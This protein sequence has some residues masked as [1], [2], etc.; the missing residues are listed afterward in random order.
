VLTTDGTADSVRVELSPAERAT[1]SVV[2]RRGGDPISGAEIVVYTDYGVRHAL[3]NGAGSF[4]LSGLAPGTAHLL[5]RAVGY[6]TLANT[7]I[8]PDS[9]GRHDCPVPPIELEAEGVVEGIVVDAEGL[10]VA[11]ARVA[12]DHAPTW[13]VAGGRT[14]DFAL[15]DAKGNFTVHQLPEGLVTLEA[16]GPDVGRGRADGVRVLAGRTTSGVIISL[17]EIESSAPA[18]DSLA[19]GSVAVTLGETGTPV[20][21]V[22]VSVV[23]GSEAERAGLAP[24]DEL[25]AVNG[26]LVATM[27]EGRTRLSGPVSEDVVVRLRRGD[28]TLSLRVPREPVHR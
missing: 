4:L 2:A 5:V 25:L 22:V 8:V 24:G 17:A 3:T 27:E 14:A 12:Q 20:A 13:L 7:L 1:G 26:A 21:V 9:D 15:S 6:A 10:P 11:G 18:R 16:Y 23:E 19:N 28:Q